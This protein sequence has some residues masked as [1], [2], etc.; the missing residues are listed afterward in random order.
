MRRATYLLPLALSIAFAPSNLPAQDPVKI[1]DQYVKAAGGNKLLSKI[2]TMTLEGTFTNTADGKSGTYTFDTKLPNRYYS[3]LVVGDKN[4]IEAYNGKSAW[5]Q[6]AAGELG[7][8]LGQD[9]L[10]LEAASSY[11]NSRFL[12]LKKNKLAL[13]FVG[14][15]QVRGKDAL[16]VEIT[17]PTDAPLLK[18]PEAKALS[19]GGNHSPTSLAPAG[20]LP[21]SPAPRRNRKHP[22][23][24]GPRANTCNIPATDHQ[25]MQQA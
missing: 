1:A 25:S 15:A 22:S 7:T 19:P 9:G 24:S 2:Q 10:Q 4:V 3:E 17:A 5:H 12:N 18:M 14:H 23:E 20:Q 11:Y 6:N 21:A 16:Q 8:L 13:A